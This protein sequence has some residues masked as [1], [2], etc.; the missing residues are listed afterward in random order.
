MGLR[1]HDLQEEGENV[2]NMAKVGRLR[3]EE[4]RLKTSHTAMKDEAPPPIYIKSSPTRC[5]VVAARGIN[6]SRMNV[7]DGCSGDRKGPGHLTQYMIRSSWSG[8]KI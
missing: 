8:T 7:V 6:V 1:R 2:V 4:L 5:T 3:A